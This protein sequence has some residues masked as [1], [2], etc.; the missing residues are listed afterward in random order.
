DDELADGAGQ[1]AR[2][3]VVVELDVADGG[4]VL[5][6]RV[7][8][9]GVG[10]SPEVQARVFE[11]FFTTKAAGEGTGLG[12][13]TVRRIVDDTR[14][15]VRFESAPGQGCAVE[16]RLPTCEP[17]TG[18][19]V[20]QS[21]AERASVVPGTRVL[22]V[23]DEPAVRSFMGQ[24]LRLAGYD[25]WEFDGPAAAVEALDRGGE[26]VALVVTDVQMRGSSGPTFARRLRLTHPSLP[27][28][29]V[30]GFAPEELDLEGGARRAFLAKPFGRATLLDAVATLIAEA[31]SS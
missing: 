4:E 23:D 7:I 9:R 12:L 14:G 1:G 19:L 3:L 25:A 31:A 24:S 30:S 15:T 5:V 2:G 16:V 10:M 21:I 6:L 17:E 29:F 22:V 18:R 26:D 11:P 28:L 20:P 27:V 13:D 8:D